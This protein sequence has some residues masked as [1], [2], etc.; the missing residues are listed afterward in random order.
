[1]RD[2]L[3]NWG[4][5]SDASSTPD[6]AANQKDRNPLSEAEVLDPGCESSLT[7]R[8]DGFGCAWMMSGASVAYVVLVRSGAC[9][10]LWLDEIPEPE[11]VGCDQW[12]CL[13]FFFM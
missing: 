10:L 2:A 6:A 13:T 11:R 5:G 1:M 8:L 3:L 12:T 7:P 4:G 9:L